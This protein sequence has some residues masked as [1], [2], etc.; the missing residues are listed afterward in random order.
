MPLPPKIKIK[1]TLLNNK[2]KPKN[3]NIN[4]TIK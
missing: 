3:K 2:E 4:K 1:G